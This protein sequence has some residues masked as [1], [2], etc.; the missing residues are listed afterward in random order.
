MK[1]R[2]VLAFVGVTRRV[3]VRIR[4]LV[5]AILVL[6]SVLALVLLRPGAEF[7]LPL[8][9]AAHIET[10][11]TSPYNISNSQSYDGT[12]H[13]RLVQSTDGYLHV[14]WMEG[15]LNGLKG[16]AYV[17]GQETIWPLWEWA[18]PQDNPA[19]TNPAIALGS[20]GTAHLVWAGGGGSPYDIYY[21][22][23]PAGGVWSSPVNISNSDYDTLYPSIDLDSTGRIWVAYQSSLSD[24]NDE[25]YVVDKPAGGGWGTPV[26]ISPSAQD[27]MNASL[28]VDRDDVIHVVW[29]NNDYSLNWEILYARYQG[30]S[31]TIPINL[32]ATAT[33]SYF[34]RIATDSTGR[35]FVAWQ[36]EI[37][38][39][40][41]FNVL[42]RLSTDAGLTWSPY[43]QVSNSTSARYPALSADDACNVYVVWQDYRAGSQT[44]IYFSRS[45]D[46]GSTWLGDE[47]VSLNGS[48][49]YYPDVVAASGGIAHIVWQD[50]APGQPDIYYSKATIPTPPPSTSTPTPLPTNTSTPL[51]TNTPTAT[52]TNTPLPTATSTPSP[53]LD[54]RPR[55]SIDIYAYDPVG[56]ALY[57]RLYSVTLMLWATSDV[58][59]TITDMWVCNLGDTACMNSPEWIPYAGGFANWALID[60]PYPCEYKPVLAAFRDDHGRVSQTYGRTIQYDNF[61]TATMVLNGGAAY[62][63]QKIVPVNSEDRDAAEPDC[64]GLRDVRFRELPEITYTVWISYSDEI[65]FFLAA[66]GPVTRTVEAQYRDYANNWRSFTDSI[67]LDEN[68]PYDGTP[69][70]LNKTAAT[71]LIPVGGLMARDD[72]SGVA[73]VWMANRAD[74]PWMTFDYCDAPP[75]S[76]EWNLG[77]GGPPVQLP[78]LHHVYVKY[79]DAA[80]V[81]SDPGNLSEVYSATI[82]LSGIHNVFLPLVARLDEGTLAVP[83]PVMPAGDLL[84]LADRPAAG[85]GEEIAL[86]LAVRRPEGAPLEGTL[87]MTLPEGLR[88]V[89]AW[90]A[91]GTLLQVG[92]HVVVSHERARAGPTPWIMVRA[93][94]EREAGSLLPV[95]GTLSW[96]GGALTAAPVQI[97]NR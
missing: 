24:T 73:R 25:I 10:T 45:S 62:A 41:A 65:Y 6:V 82:A 81:G 50:L 13:P 63:N 95:Q 57:T 18:G 23:K 17:R 1:T 60:T 78:D 53:T 79:E 52:P 87:E 71:L 75:C 5:V 32:S 92:D 30:G 21:A 8:A 33:S 3:G 42:F 48:N 86:Y 7:L 80:A 51:P 68:P 84:L 11:F 40:D 2:R 44:E 74:G 70:M 54:P 58:G 38:G 29:R 43:I 34:P 39:P 49:S 76:Y 46:C 97:Q 12:Q 77:Y 67:L 36:D 61:L 35:L 96:D 69:P 19:E 20:D 14:T 55:G 93:R 47:N 4:A 56:S 9:G 59:A 31:W 72:E 16:P 94:V 83:R 89:R 15:V 22:S 64:T 66:E 91:Y 90:S 88:V 27:D 28:I 26:K 85:V 37:G